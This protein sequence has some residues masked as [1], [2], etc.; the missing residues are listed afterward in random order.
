MLAADRP[1]S[2]PARAA[3]LVQ[4]THGRAG[5]ARKADGSP[6]GPRGRVHPSGVLAR[7]GGDA[8]AAHGRADA[9][10]GS[11]SGHAPGDG[12]R[13]SGGGARPAA[14]EGRLT[15]PSKIVSRDSP[16]RP[17][18]TTKAGPSRSGIRPLS[19]GNLLWAILGLNQ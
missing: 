5:H 8:A 13:V 6:D 17:G 11:G 3:P 7:D 16:E 19:C 9:G 10:L 12:P 2:D 15:W 14:A 1:G 4:D 18:R